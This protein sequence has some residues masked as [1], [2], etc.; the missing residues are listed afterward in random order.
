MEMSLLM[1][2]IE[3]TG[4]MEQMSVN[5]VQFE[6]KNSLNR[7]INKARILTKMTSAQMGRHLFALCIFLLT[8]S[9]AVNQISIADIHS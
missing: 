7:S 1:A 9:E 2:D 3:N 4:L 5:K 8:L 6:K